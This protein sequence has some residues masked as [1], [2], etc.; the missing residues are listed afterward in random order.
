MPDARDHASTAISSRLNC[1]RLVCKVGHLRKTCGFFDLWTLKRILGQVLTQ[2][3]LA[4]AIR[5][6]ID[7]AASPTSSSFSRSRVLRE[8]GSQFLFLSNASASSKSGAGISE[9]SAER[10]SVD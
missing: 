3:D 6:P 4:N 7:Q 2:K 8:F 1:V 5:V 9:G 10:S